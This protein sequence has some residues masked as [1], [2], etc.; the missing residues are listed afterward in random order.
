MIDINKA[1]EQHT[2]VADLIRKEQ[3]LTA[4]AKM[5]V[6]VEEAAD[7]NLRSEYENMTETYQRM[8]D[9]IAQ[10]MADPER[11]KM[12]RNLIAKSLRPELE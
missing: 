1:A 8:L 4:Y 11:G 3:L 2:T 9:F 5:K 12:Y 10:N 7:W 6:L